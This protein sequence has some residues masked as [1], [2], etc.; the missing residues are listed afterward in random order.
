MYITLLFIPVVVILFTLL[1]GQFPK[2]YN[3]ADEKSPEEMWVIGFVLISLTLNSIQFNEYS[4][5]STT[6]YYSIV[7]RSVRSETHSDH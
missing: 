5:L 7:L 6:V 3:N 4:V 2:I 1:V